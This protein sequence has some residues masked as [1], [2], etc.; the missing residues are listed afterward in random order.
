[1]GV[2]NLDAIS[3]KLR[4]LLTS[5]LSVEAYRSRC[6]QEEEQAFRSR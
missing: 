5:R 1:M 3:S 2:N 4:L 6:R